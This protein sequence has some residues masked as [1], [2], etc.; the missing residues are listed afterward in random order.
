MNKKERKKLGKLR[1]DRS[2]SIYSLIKWK[3]HLK[4][5]T[6][7]LIHIKYFGKYPFM[8]YIF[9]RN[10]FKNHSKKSINNILKYLKKNVNDNEYLK[11]EKI[12]FTQ[13]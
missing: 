13:I 1:L 11:V 3:I 8:L 10:G 12:I 6:L 9:D 4:N 2:H 5:K 7:I